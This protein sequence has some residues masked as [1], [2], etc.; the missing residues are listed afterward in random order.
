MKIGYNLK[1]TQTQKL[2]MTPELRQS[3]EILQYNALE[4]GEFINEEL[5]TNPIL[6]KEAVAPV[7]VVRV[8]EVKKDVD[9]IESIDWKRVSDEIGIKSLTKKYRDS[10]EN[11]QFDSFLASEES[12]H[13]H[14]IEQL[15]YTHLDE[16]GIR[17][18]LY[19]IQSINDSGYLNIDVS[20]VC[21]KFHIDTDYLEDI[22]LTIQG[23]DPIGVGARD[24]RECLL[25]QAV[26]HQIKDKNVYR[27]IDDYLDDLG[28]NRLGHI[29]KKLDISIEAVKEATKCI[30][31]LEP[32]PGREYSSLKDVR[33]ITPDVS[34]KKVHGDY[35]IL[36]N[37]VTAPKLHINEFYRKML[38]N[39]DL[40]ENASEYVHK[41]LTAALKLIRSIEQRRNTI[42]R[43]VEAILEH[44]YEF[45]ER[46]PIY[47]KRLTL[48]DVAEKLEMHEST[49]SR[50]TNGKYMQCPTGLYELKYFF[51]S[52]VSSHQGEGVSSE[53]IKV[54]IKDMIDKESKA[55]PISDQYIADEL[56]KVGVKISRRTVAKYRGELGILS[57]S[58]RKNY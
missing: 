32:K 28:A 58:K 29:S 27:I 43:V 51:Q 9:K 52:G 6:E 3:I 44:Q 37:D 7:E 13:E 12:L 5:L 22:I 48:K 11:V 46:G 30:K 33:Y 10:N 16:R 47:L 25:I 2:V 14:L 19:V 21:G 39:Q 24:I 38:D 53:S 56:G 15:R 20:R 40:N 49:I 36:V 23:F 54:I 1:L 17:V 26:H 42:Y 31:G 50:A 8:E 55:K 35:V 41:K 45:F 4:L 34:L 18:G 57:T